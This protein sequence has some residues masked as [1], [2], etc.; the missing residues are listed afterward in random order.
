M[1]KI[2]NIFSTS[3]SL[4]EHLEYQNNNTFNYSLKLIDIL[5]SKKKLTT[6]TKAKILTISLFR[7]D[8]KLS[9]FLL[10]FGN[11]SVYDILKTCHIL[12]SYKKIS[13]LKNQLEEGKRMHIDKYKINEIENDIK[14]WENLNEGFINLVLD[15]Q[16]KKFIKKYWN[17]NSNFYDSNI[18]LDINFFLDFS[19]DSKINHLNNKKNYQKYKQKI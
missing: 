5:E 8:K 13:K 17:I 12:S 19:Y 4:E 15:E 6:L 16:N 10:I 7:K 18:W 2:N 14:S 9:K 11:Y 3:T 1:K